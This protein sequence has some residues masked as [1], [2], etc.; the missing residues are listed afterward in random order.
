M[1]ISFELCD[2]RIKNR[3]LEKE[4]EAFRNGEKYQ[5]MEDRHR[6]IIQQ[7]DI[8]LKK[9]R[10]ELVKSRRCEEKVQRLWERSNEKYEKETEKR[11]EKIRREL[12][13]LEKRLAGSEEK[14]TELRKELSVWKEN[15][16]ALEKELSEKDEII[17][18]LQAQIN[19][20]FTNSSIPSSC[21]GPGRKTVPNTREKTGRKP[22]AQP[23]H[24]HHGRK[25]AAPTKYETIP[26]TKEMI[27]NPDLYPTKESIRKQLIKV[28]VKT[29]VI[30][31]STTLFRNR[32]TGA[33]VHAP[34]PEGCVDEVNYDGTVRALAFML[35]NYCNVSIGRTAEFLSNISNG[36]ISLSTGMV[37]NLCKEF[38]RKSEIEKQKIQKELFESP[39]INIDFTNANVCGKSGQVLIIGSSLNKSVLF[40]GCEKKGHEGIKG[41]LVENYTGNITHDHDITF[42]K[43]GSSHQECHQHNIRYLINSTELEPNLTWNIKMLD[44]I[45]NAI[46]Y[47]NSLDDNDD[48]DQDKI[49][50]L[51]NKYNEILSIGEKEYED[52]KP[53]KYNREGYNLF[54]R[55]RDY[56]ESQLYFL[57]H[58]RIPPENSLCE[59]LARVFKRKQNQMTVFRSKSG[60]NNLCDCF[61]VIYTN[62]YKGNNLFDCFI[63]IFNNS[64]ILAT[65]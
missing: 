56:K 42:Y 46:H 1:S 8:E 17:K 35:N 50:E 48:F 14:Q 21:Q 12:I 3:S 51:E 62:L 44:W 61:S 28:W 45:R 13:T 43:Y 39:A 52:N 47:R 7:K 31:F 54:R 22:G 9:I 20:D 58:R 64:P 37:Y 33:R 36:A 19:R 59:R 4:L 10:Q 55:L 32:K 11:I 6:R 24:P 57:H 60:L 34:F 53:S 30:E 16:Q 40:I 38:S 18:K 27:T 41:T 49:I 25:K 15:C 5:E 29:E 26:P 65:S 23:G 2:L 63:N